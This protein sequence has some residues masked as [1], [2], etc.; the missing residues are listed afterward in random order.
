M[1]DIQTETEATPMKY[2][3]A[4]S[5]ELFAFEE[6]GSQDSFIS[7]AFV[8]L[9]GEEVSAIRAQQE[10]AQAP[11]LEQ[12]LE[13]ATAKHDEL[14]S[15]AGLRIAPLQD[16]VDLGEASADEVAALRQWKQY[17]VAVNRVTTQVGFPVSIEWPEPPAQ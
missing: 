10:A 17:R 9:S 15:L 2:F 12:S 6:D 13:L 7:P 8:P 5:G 16:V 3:L 1:I 11:T 14:L 4:P